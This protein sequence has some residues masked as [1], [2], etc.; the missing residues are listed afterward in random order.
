MEAR[1]IAESGRPLTDLKAVGPWV[2]ARIL[3][4]LEDPPPVAEADE[5]RRDWPRVIAEAARL[6]KALEL[7]A[8]VW[9][10]DLGVELATI[11]RAEGVRWFSIGSDAHSAFEL[12]FLPFGLATASLAGIP[13]ERIL[14]YRPVDFVRSW[15]ASSDRP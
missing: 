1:D 11:A 14:N 7:D 13:R 4:W 15:V 8:T 2:A 3:S 10:Q 6:G 5:T 9:R 12:E